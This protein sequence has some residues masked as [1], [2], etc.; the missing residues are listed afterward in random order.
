MRDQRV[1]EH[2]IEQ[3]DLTAQS[4][5]LEIGCGDG[6]L[7]QEIVKHPF[8]RFGFLKLIQNGRAL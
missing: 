8:A 6:F 1:V 4:S 7:T 2:M 5:V 3:V